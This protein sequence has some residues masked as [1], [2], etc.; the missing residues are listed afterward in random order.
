MSNDVLNDVNPDYMTTHALPTITRKTS[1]QT[2]THI[3]FV[4]RFPMEDPPHRPP[5]MKTKVGSSGAF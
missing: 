1:S 3:G 4:V 5:G 2:H